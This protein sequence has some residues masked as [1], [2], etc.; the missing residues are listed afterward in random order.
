MVIGFKEKFKPLI[1]SGVKIHTIRSDT[2]KKWR[3]GMKIDFYTNVRT[4]KQ[5]KFNQ[6]V[7]VSVQEV[8]IF[9]YQQ[10]VF[11]MSNLGGT[12]KLSDSQLLV[13]AV[14]DGFKT[15]SD[16]FSFFKPNFYGRLI[17]WTD[18]KYKKETL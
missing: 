9:P 17:H 14:N 10:E 7:C 1:L 18:L 13:F 4:K 11:I 2:F 12:F 5:E 8:Q 3:P 6:G 16:F 15:L